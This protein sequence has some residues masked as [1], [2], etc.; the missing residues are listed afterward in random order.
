M[1]VT[2][3]P[4]IRKPRGPG[5]PHFLQAEA[6]VTQARPVSLSLTL[7]GC[8]GASQGRRALGRGQL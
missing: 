7:A 2:Q 3:K 4:Q 5:E 1:A 6:E 8:T